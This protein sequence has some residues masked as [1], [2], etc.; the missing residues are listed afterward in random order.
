LGAGFSRKICQAN[1]KNTL[2]KNMLQNLNLTNPAP[3]PAPG[4]PWTGMG[5]DLVRSIA[6]LACVF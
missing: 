5:A 2:Q 3:E 4:R 6:P 1:K